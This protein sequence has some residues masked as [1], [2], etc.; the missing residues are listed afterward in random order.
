MYLWMLYSGEEGPHMGSHAASTSRLSLLKTDRLLR[1]SNL[2]HGISK[3]VLHVN[4]LQLYVR[5][6]KNN[7]IICLNPIWISITMSFFLSN[8]A[9]SLLTEYLYTFPNIS[10]YFH[11][12]EVFHWTVTNMEAVFP[13]FYS[14]LRNEDTSIIP[15]RVL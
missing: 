7:D 13:V 1:T 2:I 4:W 3:I 8:P 14:E 9:L 6:L 5:H 12:I 15:V 10:S 11:K